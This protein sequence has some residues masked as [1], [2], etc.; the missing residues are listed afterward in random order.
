[1]MIL[2]KKESK[3]TKLLIHT[4]KTNN[5]EMISQKTFIKRFCD[6]DFAPL[7]EIRYIR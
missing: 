3:K 5:N 4:K 2:D 1:M 7:N 6:L